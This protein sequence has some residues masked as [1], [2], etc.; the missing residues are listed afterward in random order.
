[1]AAQY[2]EALFS[3]RRPPAKLRLQLAY[4]YIQLDQTD[5]ALRELDAYFAEAER[6]AIDDMRAA[7]FLLNEIGERDRARQVAFTAFRMVPQDPQNAPVPD[8]DF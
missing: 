4:R 1:M 7:L 6:A 5:R 3:Q 8:W 2:L